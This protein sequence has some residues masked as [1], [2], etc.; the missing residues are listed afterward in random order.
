[1]LIENKC[2]PILLIAFTNH[3]LDHLLA[4]VL[5]IGI[6]KIVRMGSR[7]SDERILE[8]SIE[9]L[10]R[11]AEAQAGLKKT[12]G[13][14]YRDLKLIEEEIEKLVK[15]IHRKTP[16]S[17]ELLDH[18]RDK[19]PEHRRN[20]NF[21]SA[22]ILD[23]Y[24][25]WKAGDDWQTAG[26]S[27]KAKAPR[28]TTLYSFWISGH[29]ITYIDFARRSASQP[30]A[31]HTKSTPSKSR[32]ENLAGRSSNRFV[33]PESTATA[34]FPEDQ[35]EDEEGDEP[36]QQ[37]RWSLAGNVRS[38]APVLP[39]PT[40][41]PPPPPSP[42]PVPFAQVMDPNQFESERSF[43]DSFF[44]R[45]G[46]HFPTIP[47]SNRDLDELVQSSDIWSMSKVERNRLNTHWVAFVS[48]ESYELH[49]AEFINLQQKHA[50][51][52]QRHEE[53][54]NEVTTSQNSHRS[55]METD[56]FAALA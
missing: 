52:R 20:F 6:K 15:K 34:T 18:L 51:A 17:Q 43:T 9:N 30:P 2:G 10:E 42:P 37:I 3:A 39:S 16:T 31:Q 29:D 56:Y 19:Y 48:A 35:S 27:G 5:D 28:D 25:Q 32:T 22:W 55:Q 38:I 53:G 45:Y 44:N 21:P 11:T 12:S 36:W 14:L 40:S 41:P 46:L 54:R 4:A 13:R 23:L 50:T 49:Q 7:S 47:S 8:L 26:R 1:M 24:A 33:L